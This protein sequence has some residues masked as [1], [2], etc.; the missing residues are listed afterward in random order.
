MKPLP[1]TAVRTTC[2]SALIKER[3][4]YPAVF[5]VG[6]VP[7]NIILLWNKREQE[8]G[9]R[10]N[11]ALELVTAARRSVGTI[12]R[13][14]AAV[15]LAKEASWAFVVDN[16]PVWSSKAQ[17]ATTDGPVAMRLFTSNEQV[18]GTVHGLPI[19]SRQLPDPMPNTFP[20]VPVFNRPLVTHGKALMG[21]GVYR[22]SVATAHGVGSD[23]V[24]RECVEKCV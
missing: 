1:P 21:G 10:E 20:G 2:A 19:I 22:A 18:H 11:A 15:S 13:Q 17:T 24:P 16:R 3:S 5:N 12:S 6:S 23:A 9:C 7:F 8:R 14:D 4:V